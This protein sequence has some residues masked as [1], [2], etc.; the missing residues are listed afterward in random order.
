MRPEVSTLDFANGV[1][2]NGFRIPALSTRRTETEVELKNGQT[3]AI[4]GL[5]NNTMNSTLQKIP[6]I[7][8]I[9]ILGLLF[10]SKAAKKDQTELVVMITPQILPRNSSG[11]TNRAAEHAGAVPGAD[12]GEEAGRSAAAR[13]HA[14][15]RR[16]LESDRIGDGDARRRGSG[17]ADSGRR[18][19][20]RRRRRRQQRRARAI[21]APS[22]AAAAAVLTPPHPPV[23]VVAPN[24]R[25]RRPVAR[26]LSADEQHALDGTADVR[27]RD[28]AAQRERAEEAGRGESQE[29]EGRGGAAGQGCARAGQA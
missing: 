19:A 4:A 13:L 2:L 16:L 14:D 1:L 24:S 12:P 28:Q 21:A 27:R 3:F 29:G 15:A 8:D 10:K 17:R 6:G 26:P 5:I 7:G 9:P 20:L 25:H 23:V 22:P 11:V 18:G